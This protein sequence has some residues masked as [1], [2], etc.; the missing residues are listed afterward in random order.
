MERFGAFPD[1]DGG[2]GSP[3]SPSGLDSRS[4]TFTTELEDEQVSIR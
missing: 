1:D 2:P 4:R 3:L